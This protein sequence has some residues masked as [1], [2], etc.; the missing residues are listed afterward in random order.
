[1]L[2][3]TPQIIITDQDA[4]IAK[5][6]SMVLPFTFQRY[7]L[8]HILNK[9]SDKMNVMMYNE[10]Y[11]ML[12]NIIKQSESP[13]EF[14]ERWAAIMEN[15]VLVDNEW[16]CTMY[17]IRSRWV[18]AYLKHIFSAGMS[19]S[20]R[21]ESGHSFFKRYVSRKNLLMDF[22]IRF[23]MALRHQ[24]NEEL[25][26]NHIDISEQPRL[27]SKF[28]MKNQMV[29]IY[30]KKIFLLF[31]TEI[32]QSHLYICTKRSTSIDSKV[33]G[34]ERNEQAKI[35]DRQ[36]Q[37]TYYMESDFISCSCRTFEF[38][39]YPCRHMISYLRKKQIM[40]LPDKYI[41]RRW[42]KN[43]KVVDCSDSTSGLYTNDCLSRSLMARHG[44][45]AHKASLIVDYA[46]LTDA[47][48]T[49]IM[50][51]F[52][53]LH[54]RVKEIDDADN[55]GSSRNKITN[56]EENHTIQDPSAVRAK[57]CGKRLKLSK[58]KSIAK[59][60]IQC[61]ICGQHGHDKRTCP[62]L[63]ESV[64]QLKLMVHT[65]WAGSRQP[66]GGVARRGNDFFQISADRWYC[67]KWAVENWVRRQ[68]GC[69]GERDNRRE[70]S[71]ARYLSVAAVVLLGQREGDTAK[72][73]G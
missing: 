22:I 33:Y 49:F 71:P 56:R 48:C 47:H 14:E 10:E 72:K 55:I 34:V 3:Q 59:R 60:N 32:D 62:Q 6:I 26:A 63:N 70:I 57:G 69:Y 15:K 46:A 18:P 38:S 25:V 37:L 54:L 35:F 13:E 8:W 44:L 36:Q 28:Q 17:D 39:G 7:C 53:S 27:T 5:A 20:Q 2:A 11:H 4:A 64:V 16:L 41:L 52:E 50:R 51:E 19:S 58:E 61:G 29:H 68:R 30:T 24:R 21:S 40:L 9:F 23:N 73:W 65:E 42:T 66:R 45:L 12:V 1:M 31:Q 43:A 67:A